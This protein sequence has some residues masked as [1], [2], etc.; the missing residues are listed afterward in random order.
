MNYKAKPCQQDVEFLNFALPFHENPPNCPFF[1]YP[2]LMLTTIEL[3][4]LMG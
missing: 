3:T 4:Q 1:R 2:E